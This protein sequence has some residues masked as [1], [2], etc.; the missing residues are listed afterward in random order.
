MI[1]DCKYKTVCLEKDGIK[2]L[3]SNSLG[4]L[5]LTATTRAPVTGYRG[6]W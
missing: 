5:E 4:S 2:K 3:S 1:Q 6:P